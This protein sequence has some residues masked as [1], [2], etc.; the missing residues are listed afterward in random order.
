MRHN[1]RILLMMLLTCAQVAVADA[2][3][4]VLLDGVAAH[5]NSHTITVGDVL[6]A[7]QPVHRQLIMRFRGEELESRLQEAFRQTL[8]ALIHKHLILDEYHALPQQLP[9]WVVQERIEEIVH[10]RFEGDHNK[11]MQVLAEEKVTLEDWKQ[12]LEENIAISYMRRE[13]VMQGLAVPPAD[14]R[15]YYDENPAMYQ[16]PMQVKLRMI[17]LK[18]TGSLDAQAELLEQAHRLVERL[19][20]GEEMAELARNFS[21]GMK[22]QDG[23]DWGWIEPGMLRPELADVL[24]TL[25]PPAHSGVIETEQEIYIV[26]SEGR[27]HARL[28]PFEEV[29]AD[30]EALLRAEQAEQAYQDWV[31][32]L[33]EQAYV[34]VFDEALR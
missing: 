12:E 25:D 13:R 18:K 32:R 8:D 22:A 17:V 28:R 23:G 14:V 33:R 4:R 15:R 27:R 16:T 24:T 20:Q 3:G 31:M 19:D 11:L 26:K 29:Q 2:N 6:T 34:R 7:V 10:D 9:D 30:I 5:V 21:D 1:V